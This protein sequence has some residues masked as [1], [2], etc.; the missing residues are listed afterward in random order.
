MKWVDRRRGY[1][2]LAKARHGFIHGQENKHLDEMERP[3]KLTAIMS[4]FS[5]HIF[6]YGLFHPLSFIFH[7]S[8]NR[9]KAG[10]THT[11]QESQSRESG[12]DQAFPDSRLKGSRLL[13]FFVQIRKL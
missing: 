6:K 12:F 11:S 8:V 4:L 3:T 10:L 7:P 9:Y 5:A 1:K 2:L 13:R